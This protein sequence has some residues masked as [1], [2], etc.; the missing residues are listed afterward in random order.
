LLT[1]NLL[2]MILN[3][4]DFILTYFL[5]SITWLINLLPYQLRIFIVSQL[6]LLGT[7]IKPNFK[8]VSLKNISF[9]FPSISKI[10]KQKIYHESIE[11]LARLIVDTI[12]I[13]TL[14]K[15]WIENNVI[16]DHDFYKK[17]KSNTDKPILYATGHLGSFA[18]MAH[19]VAEYGYP[20]NF[21]VRNFSLK[22][23]DNW[24][25]GILEKNGNKVIPRKG[26]VSVLLNKLSDKK[27]CG[28]LF[29]Q[30][31]KSNYAIFTDWFN[32]PA[33]TTFALGLAALKTE[34]LIVVAS[35]HYSKESNK[36]TVVTDLCDCEDI[37]KNKT[38]SQQE[39]IVNITQRASYIFQKH[40]INY[41]EGWFWMHKRW[42]T[43]PDNEPET[44]YK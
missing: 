10:D 31:V 1:I 37:Y 6:I 14:S 34:P 4:F 7:L 42:K 27:D 9:V 29:D 13:P 32:K 19:A 39:K 25:C 15:N 40:I 28:L 44:F 43:R 24:W 8:K 21:I 18:L 41:P 3:I 2:L 11:S 16:I 22:H 36:Y 20:L 38:L 23:I 12:S 17:I 30:N 35:M 33:A 5:R 26:A